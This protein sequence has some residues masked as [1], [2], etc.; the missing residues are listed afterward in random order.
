MLAEAAQPGNE[1][2][3]QHEPP[4]LPQSVGQVEQLSLASQVRSPQ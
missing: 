3:V 1:L 4:Q 2:V